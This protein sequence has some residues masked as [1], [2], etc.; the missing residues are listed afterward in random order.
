VFPSQTGRNKLMAANK[1]AAQIELRSTMR[2]QMVDSLVTG[3]SF[4]WLGLIDDSVIKK[5][6]TKSLRKRNMFSTKEKSNIISSIV[7]E[8]KVTDR[9]SDATFMDEQILKP[10]KYRYMASSTVEIVHDQYDTIEYVQRVGTQFESFSPKQVI[11]FKQQ[12]FDGRVSGFTPVE[13]IIVQLELLRQMWQNM[14]AMQR[15]G[16]APDKN[17]YFRE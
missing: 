11:H 9:L 14:L 13:S 2:S 15:N 8:F 17:H 1:F 4:G 5:E 12:E 3:E 7:K 6:I 16:G 10:R